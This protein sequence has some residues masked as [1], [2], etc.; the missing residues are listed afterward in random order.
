[1]KPPAPRLCFAKTSPTTTAKNANVSVPRDPG[2]TNW[3]L[4]FPENSQKM[5]KHVQ[6]FYILHKRSVLNSSGRVSNDI[7]CKWRYKL[8]G[9]SRRRTSSVTYIC[10]DKIQKYKSGVQKGGGTPST[11]TIIVATDNYCLKN[12]FLNSIKRLKEG[13]WLVAGGVG[14]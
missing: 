4:S 11:S 14:F 13:R 5:G 3:T 2:K 9:T 7:C 12:F 6:L 10:L 8:N 1:M